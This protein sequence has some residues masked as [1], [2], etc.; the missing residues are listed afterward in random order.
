MKKYKILDK[1]CAIGRAKSHI[2]TY[3]NPDQDMLYLSLRAVGER[4]ISYFSLKRLIDCLETCAAEIL[5]RIALPWQHF[6]L[7]CLYY[8]DKLAKF[9]MLESVHLVFG[10]NCIPLLQEGPGLRRAA[11][12]YEMRSLKEVKTA[13]RWNNKCQKPMVSMIASSFLEKLE[14]KLLPLKARMVESGADKTFVE[15]LEFVATDIIRSELGQ[16]ST[17]HIITINDD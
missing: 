15:N 8:T 9:E 13:I 4:T 3:I 5:Q 16:Q 6:Y 12:G 7:D 17:A 1:E 14:E 2:R 10:D 11:I